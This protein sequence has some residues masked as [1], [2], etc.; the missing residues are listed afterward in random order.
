MLIERDFALVVRALD[1]AGRDMYILSDVML[2]HKFISLVGYTRPVAIYVKRIG[3]V[4]S[5]SII[6]EM[7]SGVGNKY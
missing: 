3:N 6:Y 5:L 4:F 1:I 2:I 7:E